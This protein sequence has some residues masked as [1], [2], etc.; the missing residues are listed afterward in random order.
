MQAQVSVVSQATGRFQTFLRRLLSKGRHCDGSIRS[1]LHLRSR[2]GATS[3]PLSG[4]CPAP[5][6]PVRA[7]PEVAVPLALRTAGL[8]ALAPPRHRSSSGRPRAPQAYPQAYLPSGLPTLRPTYPQAY[9]SSGLTTPPEVS[10]HERRPHL[11]PAY[12]SRPVPAP[13]P[14]WLC[15][16]PSAH[17]WPPCLRAA[18]A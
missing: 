9:E 13:H 18:A 10:A 16:S 14:R 5:L 4:L 1:S 15:P 2:T 11:S 3:A 12:P 17:R 7:P 6:C 8:P